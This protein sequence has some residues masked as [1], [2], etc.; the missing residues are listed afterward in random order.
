MTFGTHPVQTSQASKLKARSKSYTRLDVSS[1]LKTSDFKQE[2][3]LKSKSV[4]TITEIY[5]QHGSFRIVER[6][7][8][9]LDKEPILLT[10]KG[11]TVPSLN[12]WLQKPDK[13]TI[14]GP[15]ESTLL[16]LRSLNF[17]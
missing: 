6:E 9:S 16:R 10:K 7:E 13:P 15:G 11:V 14:P 4:S 2:S 8:D 5:R 17:K 1:P 12:Y 3:Q